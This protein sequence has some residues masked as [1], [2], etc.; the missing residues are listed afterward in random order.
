MPSRSDMLPLLANAARTSRL[1]AGATTDEIAHEALSDPATIRR[2]ERARA[3]P[4]NPDAIV[5]AYARRTGRP[6]RELWADA[7]AHWPSS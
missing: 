5:T 7:L 6:A 3:W 4:R 1:E 2:F